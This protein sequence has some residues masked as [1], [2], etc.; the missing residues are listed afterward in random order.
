MPLVDMERETTRMRD[1]VRRQDKLLCGG[2]CA[3]H[4]FRLMQHVLCRY[5]C[6]HLLLNIAENVVIERKMWAAARALFRVMR[7]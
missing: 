1:F 7:C 6:V 2:P 4:G 3:S 5:A